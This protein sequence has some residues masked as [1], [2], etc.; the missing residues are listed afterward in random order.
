MSARVASYWYQY[1]GIGIGK[2][3]SQC[4]KQLPCSSLA[5]KLYPATFQLAQV[6]LTDVTYLKSN[7]LCRSKTVLRKFAVLPLATTILRVMKKSGRKTDRASKM[8]VFSN[9]LD[10]DGTGWTC[11]GLF[12]M[13]WYWIGNR[14]RLLRKF[15]YHNWYQEAK[16]GIG[17]SLMSTGGCAACEGLPQSICYDAAPDTSMTSCIFIHFHVSFVAMKQFFRFLYQL[18]QQLIQTQQY[19]ISAWYSVSPIIHE[20]N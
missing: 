20:H 11:K 16:N 2:Y 1:A 3:T 13:C 12:F 19:R 17:T 10:W 6:A 7:F 14:Y 4:T 15:W 5:A 9:I 8:F 18:N